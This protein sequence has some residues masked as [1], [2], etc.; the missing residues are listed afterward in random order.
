MSLALIACLIAFP[1]AGEVTRFSIDPCATDPA[2]K[3]LGSD[4]TIFIDS[5]V[6]PTRGLLVYLPGTGGKTTNTNGF[7]STS[8]EA[9][10]Q[11]INLMY[12]NEVPA[13][14]VRDSPDDKA[15]ANFRWEI[16]EGGDLAE[17][18]EVD[19]AN[20]I[21]N[22]LI[23]AL[24]YLDKT[25]PT[26]AWDT[27]LTDGNLDWEEIT[28]SGGSQGAGHAALI[29]TKHRVKR[30]IGFGGPKDYRGSARKPAAWYQP[31]A[32][33]ADRFY[34]FNHKQDR[35]GCGYE[36]QIEVL[37][38]MGLEEFGGPVDVDTVG[39]PFNNGRM[40]FTNYPGTELTSM[41]A[42]SSVIGDRA[43]PKTESGEPLFKPVW[44]YMLTN[45][46]TAT[47]WI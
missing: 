26:E 46:W 36:Q 28:W 35:Q 14:V 21:E 42:H 13:V 41:Q 25:R 33:P 18:I 6:K 3:P 30:V 19:R 38:V 27:Y 34:A 43:T 1:A 29:A 23:K 37:K 15:F 47:S 8:V 17:Q 16:I 12:P 5:S 20:S 40:L 45:P 11:V 24:Q 10:Y 4:H 31:C 44:H 32:T 22:R 2:I 39:P 7:C 9:G